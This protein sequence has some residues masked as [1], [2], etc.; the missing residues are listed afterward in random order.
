MRSDSR[1]YSWQIAV[2]RRTFVTWV[3]LPMIWS[4]AWL[5]TWHE[6]YRG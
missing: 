6:V 3:T 5:K 2:A 1:L 4:E